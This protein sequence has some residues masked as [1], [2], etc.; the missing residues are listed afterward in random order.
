MYSVS[1]RSVRPPAPAMDV[2]RRTAEELA[3]E[4]QGVKRS[5]T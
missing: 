3:H 4:P 1:S 5:W 2:Q